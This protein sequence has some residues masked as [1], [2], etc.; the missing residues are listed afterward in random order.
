MKVIKVDKK[1]YTNREK[2][3]FFIS[4]L[5]IADK[6]VKF[7]VKKIEQLKQLALDEYVE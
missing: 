6:R 2:L 5:A 4:Q 7:L 1:I 3:E